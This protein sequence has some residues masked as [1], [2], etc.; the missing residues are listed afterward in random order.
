MFLIVILMCLTS[1]YKETSYNGTATEESTD[2]AVLEMLVS[3][4]SQ[5]T[6]LPPE[7]LVLSVKDSSD[8]A[9]AFELWDCGQCL[10]DNYLLQ[11]RSIKHNKHTFYFF[12]KPLNEWE[13]IPAC[14]FY[15]PDLY[16]LRIIAKPAKEGWSFE[17]INEVINHDSAAKNI[18][19][20]VNIY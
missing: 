5:N 4:L 10:Q 13:T 14:P 12:D 6:S 19:G 20:T 8:T 18:Q 7:I 1:C 15:I 2:K 16:H 17:P 11:A 3:F 9:E